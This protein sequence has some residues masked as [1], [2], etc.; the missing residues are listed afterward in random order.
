V[1]GFDAA[2]ADP[3]GRAAKAPRA[4]ALRAAA[5]A[6]LVLERT[7]NMSVSVLVGQVRST[8]VDLLR[9]LGLDGDEARAAVRAAAQE[10]AA[11]ELEGAGTGVPHRSLH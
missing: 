7:G 10:V 2:L 6:T 5:R 1:R 9:G 3:H 11:E 8:A 4:A